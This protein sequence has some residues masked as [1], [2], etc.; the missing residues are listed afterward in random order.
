MCFR[1]EKYFNGWTLTQTVN[2]PKRNGLQFN[3]S[4]R[5]GQKCNKRA[6]EGEHAVNK[7][8]VHDSVYHYYDQSYDVKRMTKN[9]LFSS[10]KRD[11]PVLCCKQYRG[12]YMSSIYVIN[13]ILSLQIMT[14][15][16]YIT[17][18]GEWNTRR[19]RMTVIS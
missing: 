12:L 18:A 9:K 14:F 5:A 17:H 3:T 10:H 6:V 19:K 7:Q 16:A 11:L 15:H 8:L 4:R 13:L 1:E 2:Y